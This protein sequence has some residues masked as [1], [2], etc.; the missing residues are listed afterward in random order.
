MAEQEITGLVAPLPDTLC[1]YRIGREIGEIF[2]EGD[3]Y[4]GL[5]LTIEIDT[6]DQGLAFVAALREGLGLCQEWKKEPGG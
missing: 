2:D 6:V 4:D 1:R 5:T 3:E